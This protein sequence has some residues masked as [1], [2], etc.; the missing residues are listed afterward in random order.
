LAHNAYFYSDPLEFFRGP[1][2]AKAIYQRYLD[3]GMAKYP[4]DGNWLQAALQFAFATKAVNG[5]PLLAISAAGLIP[6]LRAR[7]FWPL[8]FLSLSPA[9]YVMSLHSGGTPIFIPEIYP[10]SHYNTRY[11]L[12]ALP[13]FAVL[14]A[15]LA[16]ALP[17]VAWLVAPL[18]AS[19]FFA[20]PVLTWRESEVNSESRRAWTTEIADILRSEY[21]PG[22]GI[23]LPFG[24]LTAAL[25]EAGIPIRESLHQGDTLAYERVIARPDLFLSEDW[26]IVIAGEPAGGAMARAAARGLPFRLRKRISLKNAPVVEVWRREN[27]LPE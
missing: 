13:L 21:R 25:T 20:A 27:P 26:A 10:F 9:F 24:D 16:G 1:D 14:G 8:A 4:G 7:C 5:W 23:L 15:A 19:W 2:S 22:R 3:Q 17:R 12:A 11:A 6:A 18:A